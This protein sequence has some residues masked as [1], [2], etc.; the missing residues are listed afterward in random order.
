MTN[1]RLIKLESTGFL[2]V[3]HQPVATLK[4]LVECNPA[5]PLSV[6]VQSIRSQSAWFQSARVEIGKSHSTTIVIVN[7]NFLNKDCEDL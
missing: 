5:G 1:L 6:W 4:S 3:G 2:S 7:K